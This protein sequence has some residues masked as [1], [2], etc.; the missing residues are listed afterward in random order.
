M[1]INSADN[2]N[3]K[4]QMYSEYAGEPSSFTPSNNDDLIYQNKYID[5]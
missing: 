1:Q 5:Q 3:V 2:R 4:K